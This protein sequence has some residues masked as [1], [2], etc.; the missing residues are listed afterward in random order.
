MVN[1]FLGHV[2][3]NLLLFAG[4]YY[5]MNWATG[6]VAAPHST[7]RL[8]ATDEEKVTRFGALF[9]KLNM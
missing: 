6:K 1:G 3:E 2:Q 5:S 4:D 7:K 9:S 8:P